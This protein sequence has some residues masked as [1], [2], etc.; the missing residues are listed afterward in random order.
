MLKRTLWLR[1]DVP[2][3]TGR[4][5]YGVYQK[6]LIE[7]SPTG[8]NTDVSDQVNIGWLHAGS[9]V[10]SVRVN[11]SV[12][13]DEI[14]F[15]GNT[16]EIE[17]EGTGASE[18]RNSTLKFVN[19]GSFA[20]LEAAFERTFSKVPLQ[21]EHPD[22]PAE[23]RRA[24]AERRLLAGMTKRQAFYVAGQP[25]SVEQ[26]TEDGRDVEVWTLRAKGMEFG[27]WGVQPQI[28][29]SAQTLRFEGGQ[30]ALGASEVSG[31]AV[32]LED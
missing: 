7:V 31:A 12:T 23:M 22:W 25:E 4:H 5:P 10:W 13:L 2:C 15:E 26:K 27:F 20:D 8:V 1:L 21:Y 17:L 30:L 24:I 28:P 11:D 19:I 18:D 9:T 3:E 32:K 14:E 29:Q 16:L 6:P